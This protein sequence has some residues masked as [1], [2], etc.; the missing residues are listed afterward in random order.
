MFSTT[1]LHS[2]GKRLKTRNQKLVC[3][4]KRGLSASG[5]R[6]LMKPKGAVVVKKKS[7][8]VSNLSNTDL[9]GKVKQ[10]EK[11]FQGL[12]RQHSQV[13]SFCAIGLRNAWHLVQHANTITTSA[14]WPPPHLQLPF[15]W[16]STTKLRGGGV[17]WKRQELDEE[18][19]DRASVVA[20][21]W[22]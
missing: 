22:H 2:L 7:V 15:E 17:V 20:A 9:T 16:F 13:K 21:S 14:P 18:K 3:R 5:L 10:N 1:F 4:I 6:P 19:Q 12:T 11:W 8:K